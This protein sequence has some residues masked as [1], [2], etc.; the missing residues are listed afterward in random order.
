[1]SAVSRLEPPLKSAVSESICLLYP[2]LSRRSLESLRYPSQGPLRRRRAVTQA[3]PPQPGVVPT[4]TLP[5]TGEAAPSP[6]PGQPG[7][8][9]GPGPVPTAEASAA[10]AC[11]PT[12]E[13]LLGRHVP[14]RAAGGRDCRRQDSSDQLIADRRYSIS[15]DSE[16]G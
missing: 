16:R 10:G 7:Q 14:A 4:R 2:D 9:N 8:G 3:Q 15:D 11:Y 13:S 12:S 1:M 5:S 6:V